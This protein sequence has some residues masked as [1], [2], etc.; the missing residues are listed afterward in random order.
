MGLLCVQGT[1]KNKLADRLLQLLQMER[2]YVQLHRD[3][4]VQS[5]TVTPTLED[6]VIVWDDSP[7]VKAARYVPT[8]CMLAHAVVSRWL[9]GVNRT[10]RVL[11]VDEADKAPLEVVCVLKGLIEDGQMLLSDGRRILSPRLADAYAAASAAI[12]GAPA[13]E[14]GSFPDPEDVIRLHPEFKMMVLAN[15]AKF[16]FL[17]N[18]FFRETGDVFSCHVIDN[19][20]RL[21][22]QALLRAYAPDVSDD[23]LERLT[24]AWERLAGL[25]D[26]GLLSY[27]YSAREL[28]SVVK[29]LQAFPSDSL[30]SAM[31]NVVGFD[32][33]E[34]HL[35]ATLQ[36]V[37][38]K[39]GI[40]ITASGGTSRFVVDL[41]Q[42]AALD[43]PVP[44]QRWDVQP[45]Q[46]LEN[47]ATRLQ[48]RTRNTTYVAMRRCMSVMADFIELTV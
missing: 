26:D 31:D 5:L 21:S 32:S 19:P 1:G 28:V 40:P 18:D 10:G 39:H 36:E 16:P 2:E 13:L 9:G 27:P 29:H 37:F 33:R 30:V 14:D 42:E 46:L 25:V 44:I 11:M 17:G 4:T 41:A 47:A 12:T 3:T 15:P 38:H 48:M 8:R 23:V 22:Q 43:P 35:M 20:D 6:G 45:K 7:L 34:P 24:E